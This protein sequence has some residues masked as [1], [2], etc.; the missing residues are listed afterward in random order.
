MEFLLGDKKIFLDFLNSISKK[1][2]VGIISH[3][4]MDGLGSVFFLDKL[5]TY[6][7]IKISFVNFFAY[8]KGLLERLTADF[9]KKKITK[10]FILDFNIDSNC[11]EE[12]DNF[13]EKFDVFFIDHHPLGN[14]KNKENVIKT[15]SFNCATQVVYELSKEIVDFSNDF[16][17][18][19]AALITDYTFK[20]RP[21][22][23]FLQRYF[24]DISEINA[25]NS[26]PGSFGSSVDRALINLKSSGKPL[27]KVYDLLKDKNLIGINR[28]GDP[29]REEVDFWVSK[30]SNEAEYFSDK[31]LYFYYFKPKFQVSSIVSS[32]SASQHPKSIIIVLVPS[33]VDEDLLKISARNNE[34]I[35]D[36]N[37]LVR[38]AIVGLKDAIAGGHKQ[39]T[40]G[41]I[42]KEDVEQFKKNIL[43]AF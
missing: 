15:N 13:K 8:E 2:R 33:E 14:I 22:L 16:L 11:P 5:L 43:S 41:T 23:E 17:I 37:T 3:N 26:V 6:K 42:R 4:D 27:V 38:S 1:D 20:H 25:F 36:V 32:I 34:G 35:R 18:L 12:F 19:C 28:L 9:K 7:K 29:V 39:A 31:D 10:V 24:P 40:G 21:N 30:L